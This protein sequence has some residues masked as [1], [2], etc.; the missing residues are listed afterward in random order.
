MILQARN[1]LRGEELKVSNLNNS[2]WFRLRRDDGEL[3]PGAFTG[4]DHALDLGWS[5]NRRFPSYGDTYR[6]TSNFEDDMQRLFAYLAYTMVRQY[7]EDRV[8]LQQGNVA[9]ESELNQDDNASSHNRD[10]DEQLA[11]LSLD[12]D[13][14]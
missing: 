14:A 7:E 2:L 12:D 13:T 5:T 4:F 10:T 9:V 6:G 11:S 8:A 1:R 3:P